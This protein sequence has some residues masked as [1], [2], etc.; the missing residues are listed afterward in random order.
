MGMHAVVVEGGWVCSGGVLWTVEVVNARARHHGGFAPGGR[1]RGGVERLKFFSTRDWAASRFLEIEA[2]FGKIEAK[3]LD[4]SDMASR[5]ENGVSNENS[6]SLSWLTQSLVIAVGVVGQ[7]TI[8][9]YL[10]VVNNEK[11]N[12]SSLSLLRLF[13]FSLGLSPLDLGI[14][15]CVYLLCRHLVSHFLIVSVE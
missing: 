12:W 15:C 9:S 13:S 6:L 11:P 8:L 2:K 10:P 3:F 5:A 1:G 7:L 4:I 14:F